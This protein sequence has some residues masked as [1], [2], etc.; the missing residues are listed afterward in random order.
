MFEHPI[1]LSIV[2]VCKRHDDMAKNKVN[3]VFELQL[4]CPSK[5]SVLNFVSCATTTELEKN[6]NSFA[7]LIDTETI[8][9]TNRVPFEF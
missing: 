2:R 9:W 4:L 6:F 7:I 1:L 3:F 5:T 8:I